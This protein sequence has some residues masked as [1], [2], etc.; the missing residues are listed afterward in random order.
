MLK[1]YF[2]VL[3]SDFNVVIGEGDAEMDGLFAELA[4]VLGGEGVVERFTWPCVL[5]LATRRQLVIKKWSYYFLSLITAQGRLIHLSRLP[6]SCTEN[7]PMSRFE[8]LPVRPFP[9]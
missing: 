6:L 4:E 1:N 2:A 9:Q 8:E 3:F 7:L 5:L